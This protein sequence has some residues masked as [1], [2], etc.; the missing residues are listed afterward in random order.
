MG[1]SKLWSGIT[2]IRT[3]RGEPLRST[4]EQFRSTRTSTK[5]GTRERITGKKKN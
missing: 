3:N 2:F 5:F 1:T 4:L